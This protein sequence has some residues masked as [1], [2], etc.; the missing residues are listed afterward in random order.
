MLPGRQLGRVSA[1]ATRVTIAAAGFQLD[2]LPSESV[3]PD[4]RTADGSDW[5]ALAFFP[6]P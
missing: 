3:E 6:L 4:R 1:S 5:P 2:R